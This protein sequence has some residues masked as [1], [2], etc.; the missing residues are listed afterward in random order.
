MEPL[1]LDPGLRRL[2]L[3]RHR[4]VSLRS[5]HAGAVVLAYPTWRTSCLRWAQRG[6]DTTPAS[7]GTRPST[8]PSIGER[9]PPG[10]IGRGSYSDRLGVLAHRKRSTGSDIYCVHATSCSSTATNPARS[11]SAGYPSSSDPG[12]YRVNGTRR[13]ASSCREGA[14]APASPV[15]GR[16]RSIPD[17]LI[18]R[19]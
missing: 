2:I 7:P 8:I 12:R 13:R 3:I 4:R 10:Q 1:G 9:S 16:V 14:A 11:L 19:R 15:G 5:F 6:D 17:P 18:H